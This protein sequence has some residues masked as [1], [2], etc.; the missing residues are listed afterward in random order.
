MSEIINKITFEELQE[1]PP[2]IDRKFILIDSSLYTDEA[3]EYLL[4]LINE[5]DSIAFIRDRKKIYTH[6]EYFG[7]DIWEDSL[8][9]FGDFQILDNDSEEVLTTLKAEVQK[10]TLRLKGENHILLLPEEVWENGVKYKTLRFKWDAENSIDTSVFTIDD[11]TAEYNLE[12]KDNKISVNKY[13]PIRIESS[14]IELKEYDDSAS[15]V[16]FDLDIW[17][18]DIEKNIFVTSSNPNDIITISSDKKHVVATIS[19][20]NIQT[21]Y[22][23]IYSDSKKEDNIYNSLKYGFANV[24]SNQEIT[25][26][27][28]L[29]IEDRFISENSCSCEFDLNIDDEEYGWFACPISFKPKFIDKENNI[30][31][32]WLKISTIKVYSINLEYNV[33]R[34]ENSGLGNTSWKV[35]E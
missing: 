18:T 1:N 22:L 29:D 32:G 8:F 31:G 33:Y 3:Y 21:N 2:V 16:T 19:E 20:K 5:T 28:F 23:I 35:I 34:T 7:G 30:S 4:E 6:G 24:C 27:N 10:E 13:I 9:Y 12:I 14:E 11:P 17:G 15:S 26:N 25:V